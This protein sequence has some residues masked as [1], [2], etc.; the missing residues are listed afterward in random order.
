[1]S[2]VHNSLKQYRN[3]QT[4]PLQ[5]DNL[6]TNKSVAILEAYRTTVNTKWDKIYV[7]PNVKNF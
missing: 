1:M 5:V 7:L 6:I 4:N 2:G 3:K